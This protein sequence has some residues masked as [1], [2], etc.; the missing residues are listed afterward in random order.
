[1]TDPSMPGSQGHSIADVERDTGLAKD[2]LRVWERRYGFPSPVRDPQGERRYSDEDLARLRHVRRLLDAGHRPGR[3]VALPLDQLLALDT[4]PPAGRMQ[5]PAENDWPEGADWLALMQRMDAAGLREALQRVLAERGLART[6]TDTVAPLSVQVGMAWLDGRLAVPEEH[7]FSEAVQQV[8]RPALAQ[9]MAARPSQPPRV[10]LTTVPGEPHSLGL[11]MAECL[12]VLEGCETVPLGVQT[13][14][15]DISRAA[16]AARA[17]VV[18]LGFSAMQ[19]AREVQT[20]LLR[21]RAALPPGVALWAGGRGVAG[22]RPRLAARA[23]W[24]L[25][26]LQDIAVAVARWRAEA[27]LR[28]SGADRAA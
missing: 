12:L 3:V 13:P 18:A 6:V 1:M 9:A 26:R 16:V 14:L 28:E 8:L 15:V 19:S 2:T 7:L 21:L 11:L 20:Q 17:D 24:P 10:L 25:P 5:P 23:H 22:R 27:A 4:Q